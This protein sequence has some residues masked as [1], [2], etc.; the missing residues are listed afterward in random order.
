[1]EDN[2]HK[3]RGKRPKRFPDGTPS[4]SVP[5]AGIANPNPALRPRRTHRETRPRPRKLLQ[6][7]AGYR[8]NRPRRDSEHVRPRD[9]ARKENRPKAGLGVLLSGR[10]N[11][12]RKRLAVPPRGQ[13][14]EARETGGAP[15]NFAESGKCRTAV[16][17][18]HHAP[19]R[20]IGTG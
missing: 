12:R 9:S 13:D 11:R 15:L 17:R 5:K 18:L 6:R 1:M 3:A 19:E 10:G 16:F 7:H 14:E 2:G 4:R 20:R 8:R